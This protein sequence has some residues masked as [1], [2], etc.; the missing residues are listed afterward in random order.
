MARL[1]TPVNPV[2]LSARNSPDKIWD[3]MTLPQLSPL[4][5]NCVPSNPDFVKIKSFK[6]E[7]YNKTYMCV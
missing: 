5:I 2:L 4:I 3:T 1:N 7:E 6:C